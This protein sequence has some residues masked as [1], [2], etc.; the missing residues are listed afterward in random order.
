MED[1]EFHFSWTD[2]RASNDQQS[3]CSAKS[4]KR[5]QDEWIKWQRHGHAF[6]SWDGDFEGWYQSESEP[7]AS[8][9]FRQA[10]A[11]KSQHKARQQ[12]SLGSLAQ[13]STEQHQCMRVLGV[14]VLEPS[15]LKQ[16]FLEC[17][18][19]WHPDRHADDAKAVAESKFKEAQTA[20]QYLLTCL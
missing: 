13:R 12:S 4:A 20:Y 1:T 15:L 18:K 14:S 3:S 5:H 11:S 17:A 10:R 9:T 16:A 7:Q 2:H 6:S 19:K 8:Y